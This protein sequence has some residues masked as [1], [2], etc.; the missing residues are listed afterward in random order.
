MI[1]WLSR[2]IKLLVVPEGWL[3]KAA[4]VPQGQLSH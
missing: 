2:F 3:I 1:L 4:I